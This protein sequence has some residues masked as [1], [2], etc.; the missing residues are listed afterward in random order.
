MSPALPASSLAWDAHSCVPLLTDT[1]FI[2]ALTRHRQAGFDYV[3]INVGMDFNPLP[4]VIRLLARFR[5]EL[6]RHAD[7]FVLTGSV[8]EVEA[9]HAAGKLAVSFDLEGSLM[10]HDDPDMIALFYQL[11][12]RQI[13]F[14][15]NRSNAAGGGCHDVDN[16]LT[17][18]GRQLVDAVNQAGM[19][20]DCSHTGRRTSLDIM[21][22]SPR[23]VIFSHAN[24]LALA[25]H[26][27]NI[28]DEQI[29]ACAATGGVIGING[30]GR[31]LGGT[32][33]AR[34]ARNVDYIAQLVGVEHVGL[35]LDFSYYRGTDD[36][37]PGVP[38]SHWWPADAGYG[39]DFADH[40]SVEPEQLA[41]IVQSLRELGWNDDHLRAMLGGN[42][43][44]VA[45]ACWK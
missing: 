41:G 33:D 24:P 44:R 19:L 17:A 11:G 5:G 45:R 2:G 3:S 35:G 15:Y 42:F 13:H 37:P 7:Q 25:E 9:A 20:M 6:A 23:P 31:F 10:L 29:K 18:Y 14:A 30:I 34:V 21:A 32:D 39:S 4:D 43:L 38:R 27:R 26:G 40:G 12:V 28:T 22:Y 16:G 1:D 36:M 8:A